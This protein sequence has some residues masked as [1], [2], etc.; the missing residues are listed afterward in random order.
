MKALL[1]VAWVVCL[2]SLGTSRQFYTEAM[3]DAF[4]GLALASV[5]IIHLRVR[6]RWLD[7]ALIVAGTALLA[8]VD[9]GV[10]HYPP[11]VMAWFSFLGLSSFLILSIRGIWDAERR[12]LICAWVPAALFVVSD[13]FADVMLA[14]TSKAHPQTLDLYLLS[15]DL[16]LGHQLA[17]MAGQYYARVSWLHVCALIAYVGLALPIAMV[18]A[19]RLVRFKE[20][21][22]PV[23]WAFLVAGP[24]GIVLYNLFPA[25]GPHSLFGQAFPFQLFP[26]ADLPRLVLEPVAIEGPRNAMPS[27]HLGWTLLAWWYSKGLSWIERAVAFAFLAFTAFATLGTGEHWFA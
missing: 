22:L 25:C 4:F 10:L 26:I 9:F 3:V 20:K 19:G 16:S 21:A 15:F 14:W 17:F 23:M 5:V 1:T 24:A 7:A 12:Y 8:A 2:V 18:Y 6:P 13:Y 27:L 11:R